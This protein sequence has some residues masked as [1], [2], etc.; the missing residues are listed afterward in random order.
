VLATTSSTT[1]YCYRYIAE[2]I[3]FKYAIDSTGIYGGHH[4]AMKAAGHGPILF[5]VL[6]SATV[7]H[8]PY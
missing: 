7:S 4:N 3:F 1:S 2:G 6:F 8:G 5:S